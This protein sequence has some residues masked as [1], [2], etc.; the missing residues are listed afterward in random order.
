MDMNWSKKIFH[1]LR[2]DFIKLN[3][4]GSMTSKDMDE[5]DFPSQNSLTNPATGLPMFGA[6]D[7]LGNTIGSSTS[8][9]GNHHDYYQ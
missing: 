4:D 6:F 7:S 1:Y 9:G 8:F 2:H 5:D 3:W